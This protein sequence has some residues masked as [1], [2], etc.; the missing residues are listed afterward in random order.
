MW[1][2]SLELTPTALDSLLRGAFQ[3]SAS[4]TDYETGLKADLKSVFK[5]TLD[6]IATYLAIFVALVH[7]SLKHTLASN[8]QAGY[9]P[10]T[11]RIGRGSQQAS[12]F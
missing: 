12:S 2:E 3:S 5:D 4:C 11:G 9:L 10:L 1:T 6:A 7:M 8:E